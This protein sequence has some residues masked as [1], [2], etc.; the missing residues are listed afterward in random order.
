[1]LLIGD[2]QSDRDR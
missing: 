2:N 1:M